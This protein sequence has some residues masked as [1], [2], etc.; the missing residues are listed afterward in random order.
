LN[1]PEETKEEIL[2]KH[3][4][5]EEDTQAEEEEAKPRS[6]GGGILTLW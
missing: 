4:C 1:T 5:T 3:T 6:K 2:P